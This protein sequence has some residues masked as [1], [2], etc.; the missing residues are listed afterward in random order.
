MQDPSL[1]ATHPADTDNNAENPECADKQPEPS[2]DELGNT[3][4][5]ENDAVSEMPCEETSP[6]SPPDNKDSAED[7]DWKSIAE[8]RQRAF[9]DQL[10]RLQA[11]MDNLRKRT[12]RDVANARAYALTPFAE[13][14]IPVLD[15]LHMG[16][17]SI[18]EQSS[19]ADMRQ[20]LELIERQFLD[21]F[22]N[23]GIAE[24]NPEGE[25]F[26]P[27]LHEAVSQ[28]D[29]PEHESGKIIAVF[30][31]GYTLNER[32]LRPAKVVVAK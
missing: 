24:T 26:D 7:L 19:A 4:E 25:K 17:Q 10:L 14:L 32:L 29:D 16:F 3:E 12:E 27:M 5:A 20:G 1:K 13:K 8:E 30:Q 22:A 21:A 28:I 15:S 9:A 11:E 31:K 23:F 18:T 2:P 6:A